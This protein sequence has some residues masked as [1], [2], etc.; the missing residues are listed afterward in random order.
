MD[1]RRMKNSKAITE[2][3]HSLPTNTDSTH[4]NIKQVY[5]QLWALHTNNTLLHKL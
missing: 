2:N 5:F 4:A 1:K 3:V